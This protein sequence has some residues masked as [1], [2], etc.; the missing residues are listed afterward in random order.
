MTS[1]NAPGFS[2]TLLNIS[3]TTRTFDSGK[4]EQEILDLYDAPHA[5]AAWP[6]GNIYPVPETLKKRTRE[7][8]FIELKDEPVAAQEESKGPKV[9]GE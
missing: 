5:S 2:I 8:K 1:L 6:G 9:S 4:G 7:E 3:H